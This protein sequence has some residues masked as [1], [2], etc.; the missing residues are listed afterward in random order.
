MKRVLYGEA[1]RE[2][3]PNEHD[4]A[5][6]AAKSDFDAAVD[7]A[8]NAIAPSDRNAAPD[9]PAAN[10][11]P[12]K[13]D[14]PIDPGQ[15]DIPAV[16]VPAIDDPELQ[17]PKRKDLKLGLDKDAQ[18]A[19]ENFTAGPEPIDN[20]DEVAGNFDTRG[21]GL[22]STASRIQELNGA[23][24]QTLEPTPLVE[25]ELIERIALPSL[26]LEPEQDDEQA[27]AD[28]IAQT[29]TLDVVAINESFASI[30]KSLAAFDAALSAT[31]TQLSLPS[32]GNGEFTEDMKRAIIATAENTRRLVERSQSGGLVFA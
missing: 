20:R 22:G 2:R 19:I 25:N 26:T 6:A 15:I 21:L 30:G 16:D 3:D 18:S 14:P 1:G 24:L 28:D 29:P 31:T 27:P 5:I 32:T 10:P 4:Q 7:R 17:P 23:P 11:L 12:P 8:N 9:D 13:P